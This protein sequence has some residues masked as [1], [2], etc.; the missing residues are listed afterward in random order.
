MYSNTRYTRLTLCSGL[1]VRVDL[2]CTSK[3]NVNSRVIKALNSLSGS[4]PIWPNVTSDYFRKKS[5]MSY[6]ETGLRNISECFF[7]TGFR[8][9]PKSF[10][11]ASGE[12]SEHL[13]RDFRV[14]PERF[15]STTGKVS[16]ISGKVSEYFRKGF[17]IPTER[18]PNTFEIHRDLFSHFRS[19]EPGNTLW[20]LV[21]V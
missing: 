6:T 16:N 10:P 2:P 7:E 11:N 15:P 20:T 19:K 12:V 5:K 4:L 3:L 14:P 1:C 21:E 17:R 8:I 18:F 13:R 9:L